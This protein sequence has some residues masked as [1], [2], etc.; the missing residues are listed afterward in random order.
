MDKKIQTSL[1]ACLTDIN[2]HRS[3][4]Q[5][6]CGSTVKEMLSLIPEVEELQQ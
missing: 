1:E 3:K 5:S 6:E 2:N 4:Q